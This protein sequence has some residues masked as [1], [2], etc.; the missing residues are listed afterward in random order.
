MRCYG[1]H[2]SP[3]NFR[4]P[5]LCLKCIHHILSPKHPT[6]FSGISNYLGSP[7]PSPD[8]FPT[9]CQ[10]R[11]WLHLGP[12][13]SPPPSLVLPGQ[14]VFGPAARAWPS[15]PATCSPVSHRPYVSPTSRPRYRWPDFSLLPTSLKTL[16]SVS[17]ASCPLHLLSSQGRKEG[18]KERANASCAPGTALPQAGV[19]LFLCWLRLAGRS[20]HLPFPLG[21]GMSKPHSLLSG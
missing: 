7:A 13:H 11:A 9:F 8:V 4:P 3:N 5:H 12:Q 20:G 21:E 10:V 15:E 14:G 17:Q 16:A 2:R 1:C 19:T 18:R 6:L